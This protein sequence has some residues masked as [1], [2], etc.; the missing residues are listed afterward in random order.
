MAPPDAAALLATERY[1]TPLPR[2]GT[3]GHAAVVYPHGYPVGMSSLALHLLWRELA[4]AG[5]ATDRAFLDPHPGYSLARS[6][7]LRDFDLLAVTCS[8]ELD[9]LHLPRL[10]EAGGV[11]ALR[12]E[13]GPKHP[14]V[15]A[16]GPAV[17]ANPEPLAP[18]FDLIFIGE[19]EP[20]W[21][22]LSAALALAPQSR[23]AALEAAATVPGVYLPGDPPTAPV[24]RQVLRAVDD[25]PCSSVLVTPEAELSDIF[26]VETG[27]GCPQTCRFCLA[28]QLYHPFR[29][30]SLAGLLET[31]RP[32]LA[33]TPKIGLLGA[34]LSDHPHLLALVETLRAEGAQVSTSSLRVGALTPPLVEALAATGT[35]S[36]T[37][38]PETGSEA[39]RETLGKP[40][41]NRVLLEAATTAQAAGLH[42]L[43]LYFMFGLPEE[44]EEDL[45][46]IGELIAQ[47]RSAAPRL[48]L[49]VAL[50]PLVPKP[51]T[52]WENLPLLPTA[53]LRARGSRL[54]RSLERQG[55]SANVGSSRWTLV[56]TALSR[57]GQ[58]LA[59]AILAASRAGGDFAAVRRG[60]R[61]AGLRLEDYAEASSPP[62]WRVVDLQPCPRERAPKA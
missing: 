11:P 33:V 37:L 58:E 4:A 35:R 6:R 17:T 12:A 3:I 9:Y 28:R 47:V 26:L 45:A 56:Q 49:E 21:P 7:P 18:F 54:R 19:L 44:T 41:A 5:W 31:I 34:A 13:R 22:E 8:Y 1:V 10:L 2:G 29:P 51:H 61:E 14:L 30:R 38:A 20:I 57:G 24:R 36:L 46:A 32:G 25:H 39:L 48:R 59:P 53:E 60:W 23:S 52:P 16:G 40:I 15:I 55:L 43:K 27:R 42:A 62:P 50:S